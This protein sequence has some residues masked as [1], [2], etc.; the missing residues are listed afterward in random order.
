ML[1]FGGHLKPV[2]VAR[3]RLPGQGDAPPMTPDGKER[4]ALVRSRFVS[5]EDRHGADGK[6]LCGLLGYANTNCISIV[7][8]TVV[9][10]AA[11]LSLRHSKG[12]R[13]SLLDLVQ[14]INFPKFNVMVESHFNAAY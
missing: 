12:T 4:V 1:T 8:K 10:L 6:A 7:S 2:T 3:A 14:R 13:K 9:I 11:D 5:N